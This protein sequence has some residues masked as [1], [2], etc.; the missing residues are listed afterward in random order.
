VVDPERPARKGWRE[1]VPPAPGAVL[2]A[3]RVAGGSLALSY[4]ERAAS[5]LRLTDLEGGTLR[6]VPLP[7]LGSLMGTGAEWD[8]RELFFGFSSYTVPPSVYR[9]DLET[10]TTALWRRVE[11]T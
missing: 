4:L 2:E 3:V 7:T 10:G 6:D 11:S 1:I 9:I 5:R 8:G